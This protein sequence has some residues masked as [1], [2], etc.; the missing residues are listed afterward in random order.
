MVTYMCVIIDSL[1][2]WTFH[3]SEYDLRDRGQKC[4]K[5]TEWLYIGLARHTL[6]WMKYETFYPVYYETSGLSVHPF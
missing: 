3:F 1:S 6:L 2:S 5:K 4:L